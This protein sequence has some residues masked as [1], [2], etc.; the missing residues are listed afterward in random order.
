MGY[1]NRTKHNLEKQDGTQKPKKAQSKKTR[2]DTETEQ[3]TI[4][5]DKMGYRNRTKHNL[6]RQDE[7]Q[8]PNK[9]QS[10]KTRWDT[11]TEESTI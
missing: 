11:E 2:L 5:K 9:V 7:I 1:R 4:Q 6:E 8:K 10:S 3:G